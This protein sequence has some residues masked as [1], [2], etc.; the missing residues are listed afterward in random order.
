[1]HVAFGRVL[2]KSRII[3]DFTDFADVGILFVFRLS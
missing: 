3:A 1:M 2:R